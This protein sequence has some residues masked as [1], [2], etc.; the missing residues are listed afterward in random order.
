MNSFLSALQFLTI[1]P[2][3]IKE[4]SEKDIADLIR[5]FH[6]LLEKANIFNPQQYDSDF[7]SAID[8]NRDYQT[9]SEA[10]LKLVK[11]IIKRK[12]R[13]L[14]TTEIQEL[15]KNVKR[16]DDEIKDLKTSG[17]VGVAGVRKPRMVEVEDWHSHEMIEVDEDEIFRLKILL[18]DKA[19]MVL[20]K[21]LYLSPESQSQTYG[22]SKIGMVR[23]ALAQ[24]VISVAQ[25][26]QVG[27]NPQ[28]YG[29]TEP[30][31]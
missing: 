9:N 13:E 28:D 8:V 26:R 31:A 19:H 16:L 24:G 5:E 14:P 4:A 15:K 17:A 21:Y 27:L 1:I 2:L 22:C 7:N 20:P 6:Y 12:E 11:N 3:K 18:Y 10:N 23:I 29:I 25:I 30:E